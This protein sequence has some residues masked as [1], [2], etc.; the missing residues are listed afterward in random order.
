MYATVHTDMVTS[1]AFVA[2]LLHSSI[3]LFPFCAGITITFGAGAFA[4]VYSGTIFTP[5]ETRTGFNVSA[6]VYVW[7]GI[8]SSMLLPRDEIITSLKTSHGPARSIITVPSET[9]N[10]TGIPPCS[11]GVIGFVLG[12]LL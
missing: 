2:F 7:N 12:P 3:A 4:N 1:V 11:G 8:W 10:A 5:P 9:T 6:T